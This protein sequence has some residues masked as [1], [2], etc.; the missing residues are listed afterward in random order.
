MKTKEIKLKYQ[1][2][3]SADIMHEDSLKWL[4]ELNFIKD[5][6]LFFDDLVKSYTLQLIDSKHFAESKKIVSRLSSSQKA[7]NALLEVVK[8]HEKGLKI[9]VDGIDQ[10]NEEDGYKN[11]HVE[12]ITR[13]TKFLENYRTFKTQLFVLIKNIIKEGKQKRLLQ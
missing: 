1:P 11:E 7:T 3:L 4:S 5:E 10:L 2:W 8:K 9:M 12:L 6:Q 13:V